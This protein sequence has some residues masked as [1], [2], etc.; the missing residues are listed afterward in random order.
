MATCYACPATPS[1]KIAKTSD[2]ACV[3]CFL[4]W[5]EEDVHA[6]I[7]ATKIFSRGEKVAIGVS[8]G[9]D[10]TVLAHTLAILNQRYDY[11]LELFLV[12]IDEGIAGYRDHSI[13]EVHKNQS[14]LQL[15]LKILSYKDLY[16]WTMDEIV[17]RIGPK[18]NCTF[19]GVFRRQA[20]DRGAEKCGAFKVATGHNADDVAETV[21]MNLLRGDI[22]RLQRSSTQVSGSE[23]GITRVKPFRYSYQK[24]VVFYAHFKKLNYFSVECSY[25]PNAYR[26]LVRNHLKAIERVSPRVIMEIVRSGEA[27]VVPQSEAPLIRRKCI[28]CNY[29]SS[30]ELCQACRLL[31]GLNIGES[32]HDIVKSTKKAPVSTDSSAATSNGCGSGGGG[33]GCGCNNNSVDF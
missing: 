7:T 6:T 19:C 30:Q 25:S 10:S 24:D 5:F 9:K 29:T 28:Q 27:V 1:I 17:A 33:D 3:P 16:G 22:A 31:S 13:R 21:L 12:C 26:G 23:G 32:T 20:L 2:P 15:P 11:G 8:G 18:N 14:D 4:N